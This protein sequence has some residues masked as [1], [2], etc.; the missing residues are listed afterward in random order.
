MKDYILGFD[1]GFGDCKIVLG[2]KTE[3]IKKFKFPTIIGITKK[4]DDISD[5]R[6][7][8]Y[9]GYHFCVGNDAKHIQSENLIDMTEYKNLEYYAP[10]LLDYAIRLCGV[11]A[12]EISTVVTGLSIAQINNSGRFQSKLENYNIDETDYSFK[13]YVLPQG[14]G[15]KLTVDKYFDNFPI[16]NQTFLGNS[17]YVI[18]DMGF[19]TLDFLLVNNGKTSP[20]LFQGIEQEGMMKIAT[21]VAKQVHNDFGRNIGLG[22][23]KQIIDTKTYK[24]RGKNH[25][26]SEMINNI[27][28]EYMKGVL[29]LIEERFPSILD[30][31]DFVFICGG[32]STIFKTT[33]DN[34]IRTP[35][36]SNEFYNAIGWWIYGVSKS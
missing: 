27:K 29:E 19:N 6:V 21:L 17:T 14:A 32:G 10:L 20:N 12:E 11:N 4:I 28:K 35:K 13:V 23:A 2:T 22:E 7:R 1:L 16:E 3:V 31:C 36:N 18:A 26:Y 24:L 30:K 8:E 15:C 5:V 33:D 9:N 34:F 25:D